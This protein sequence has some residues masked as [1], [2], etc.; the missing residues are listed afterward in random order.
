MSKSM[1]GREVHTDSPHG[2]TKGKSYLTTPAALY[3]RMGWLNQQTREELSMSSTW[4][5]VRLSIQSLT[6]SWTLNW[7]ERFYGQTV[8]WIRY[9]LNPLAMAK[10]SVCQYLDVQGQTSRKRTWGYWWVNWQ[11]VSA[12]QKTNYILCCIKR[13]HTQKVKGHDSS[14]LL[15]SLET[16]P[17]VL[18]SAQERLGPVGVD[19]EEQHKNFK[20]H[21]ILLL[22]Q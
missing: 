6:M 7:R 9:C 21:L 11:C 13:K 1:K 12:G 14:P 2:C 5:S 22:L 18:C 10:V 8:R 19:P 17:W 16:P 15:C 20:F 3:G 4:T